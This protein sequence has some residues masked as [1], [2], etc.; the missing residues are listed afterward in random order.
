MKISLIVPCYNEVANIQKGVLDKIGNFTAKDDRFLEVIIVDDGS[1]DSSKT[2]VKT[3]YL[4]AFPKFKLIT[5]NHQGKAFAV[6]TGIKQAKADWVMFSDIDLATPI[7]EADKL[8]KETG[9]YEIVI[10]SRN[11]YRKGAPLLRKVMAKGF[12]VLRNLIIGLKGIKDTQCGFKIF[13]KKAAMKIVS[14][15][16]VFHN[17]RKAKGSSVSAGFDLEFIFLAQKFGYR[18]KEVPVI[19]R[20]V[21]TKNVNF[22]TDSLETLKD[23]FKIK[24]L[25]ITGQYDK[26]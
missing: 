22:I 14:G 7:E 24:Y 2:I 13:E 4:T 5:N 16:K 1:N 9:G 25:A 10:G 18:I 15:L 3:K 26:K 17:N 11:S 6:L 21:E 8:I 20:H 12:I 23:I 19:W